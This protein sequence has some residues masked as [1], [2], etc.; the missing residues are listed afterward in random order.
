MKKRGP[1]SGEK[2]D[3]SARGMLEA[4]GK[5]FSKA[6]SGKRKIRGKIRIEDAMMS[7]LAMFSLKSPSLLNFDKMLKDEILSHNLEALYGVKNVPCDTYMREILDE[8]NPEIIRDCYKSIF[9]M[10]QRGKLL[11][12]YSFL[13]G[14]LIA[15]DG[16]EQFNS[17]RVHCNNCC[18]RNHQDGSK[19]YYHQA[20]AGVVVSPGL[21]QV[22]PLCPE[23]IQNADGSTKNDC[24]RRATQRF[25][26][27]L[28]KE[29]PRLSVTIVSDALSANAPQINEIKELGY[30]FI[31]NVKPSGNKSL[32]EFIDGLSLP[33]KEAFIGKNCYTLRY[34]NNIPLN[35]TKNTPNVNFLECKTIEIKG[36]KKIEQRFTW[37]TNHLI[38]N[39][40]A[41]LIAQGGRARWKIENETFNTLKNQGYQ[42]E[43]N[44]GHG[45]KNLN[46]VF[47]LLMML[48]F[49]I[50]QVQEAA[51]GLFQSALQKGG[52][53]KMLWEKM[54]AYF[55]ICQ[56]DSWQD[57]FIAIS[58]GLKAK[59]MASDT[60]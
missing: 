41:L 43:H 29:H 23:P 16:V 22:I 15:T 46:T 42:F 12:N 36:K 31:I 25:L 33:T 53:R 28:K 40:N 27:N 32:F 47:M 26:I 3:L 55:L 6:F 34:I 38:D 60:S 59:I 19:S 30:H 58:K 56:V 57:L 1:Q 45:N 49:L 20:F 10:V 18:V 11:E 48:A 8:V 39:K 21:K 9:S 52:T 37:V 17:K 54:R 2:K 7:A 13:G 14:F 44:F 24:E 35:D 51:C 4:V 50:D 5:T